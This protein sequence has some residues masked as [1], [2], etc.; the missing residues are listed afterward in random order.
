MFQ[1]KFRLKEY[2]TFGIEATAR[3]FAAPSLVEEAVEVVA[4]AN[5]LALPL[6]VLGGGSNVL[7][8][9]DFEGL[10]IK[11]MFSGIEAI[12][13][14]AD[15]VCVAAGAGEAWDD[16][17]AWCVERNWGGLENLSH[18]P[19]TVGAAPVQ[20]IGA[21]GVEAKDTI[22][23]VEGFFLDTLERFSIS[24][25]DCAFGYRT[26]L[27]KT[28][29]KKRVMITRVLFSLSTVPQPNTDYGRIEQ[30]LQNQPD[31]SIQSVRQAVIAI[32]NQKLPDPKKLGNAGSFF[33][34]PYVDDFL[35]QKIKSL[36][37]DIPVY[38]SDLVGCSKLPAAFLIDKCGWKGRSVGRVGVHSEQPLVLVAY[39]GAEGTHVLE[40][41]KQIQNSV[42]EKFGVI[43]EPEVD[44]L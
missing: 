23:V 5:R 21:Y 14:Y 37:P 43:L 20:N 13:Q 8:T 24:G 25:A 22:S 10:V 12:A 15:K 11:P 36:Y 39:E 16:L 40:L 32:R 2:N 44:V 9:K 7:F 35:V 28:E 31:R 33:K 29:L 6:F 17:V 26:S 3:Y 42:R 18:I 27:F 38:G 4:E 19:G 30:E 34:N 1:S 41:S